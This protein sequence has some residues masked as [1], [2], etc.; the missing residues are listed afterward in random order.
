[1]REEETEYG[2]TDGGWCYPCIDSLC[3]YRTHKRSDV[4]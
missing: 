4:I 2:E 3:D 1:M